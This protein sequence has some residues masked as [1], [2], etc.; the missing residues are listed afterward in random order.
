VRVVPDGEALAA[1]VDPRFDFRREVLLAGGLP[2]RR[3]GIDSPGESR[4]V[5]YL[6]DRLQL[7]VSARRDA[8]V[9]LLDSY[10]PGWRASVDGRPAPVLRVNVAFRAVPVPAG[11]HRVEMRYR[12][13]ALLLGVAVSALVAA[14]AAAAAVRRDPTR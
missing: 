11:D 7:Q 8:L 5:S 3:P 1:L 4:F 6:P 2:P 9:V 14:I 10:D 12:P 13:P